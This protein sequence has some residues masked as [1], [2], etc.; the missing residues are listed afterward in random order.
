MNT[1]NKRKGRTLNITISDIGYSRVQEVCAHLGISA[2]E[3]FRRGADLLYSST[4]KE[5][6]GYKGAE[7]T[8]IKVDKNTQ[9]KE[10]ESTIQ[11]L[12]SMSPAELFNFLTEKG[13]FAFYDLPS[14]IKNTIETGETS[15]ITTWVQTTMDP[16]G[17]VISRREV[18]TIDEIINDLRKNKFI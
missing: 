16:D 2:S 14:N 5:R 6:Y 12:R 13:Y 8:K 3:A 15:G 17:I 7:L 9:Q 1:Q 18:F 11:L 4:I 10:R